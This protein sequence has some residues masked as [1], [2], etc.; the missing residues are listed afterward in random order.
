MKKQLHQLIRY[1]GIIAIFA[2]V[3]ILVMHYFKIM[4]GNGALV[5]A[6]AVMVAGVVG[7]VVVSKID[8][9]S[10]CSTD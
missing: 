6:G 2:G 4:H 7:H 3:L 10:K 5:I 9:G 8:F 1:S